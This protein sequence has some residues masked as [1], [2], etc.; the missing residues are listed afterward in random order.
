MKPSPSRPKD[1]HTVPEMHLK[2]FIDEKGMVW[3]YDKR[4]DRIWSAAPRETAVQ[5]NFY[6]VQKADDTYFDEIEHWLSGVESKASPIYDHLLHGQIPNGQERADFATFIASMY[7]CTPGMVRMYAEVVGAGYNAMTSVITA[8][9]ERFDQTMDR[10]EREVGP[11]PSS[12]R[13][14]VFEFARDPKN[15]T[16]AVA[17]AAGLPALEASDRLQRIFFDMGWEVVEPSRDTEFFITGDHPVTRIIPTLTHS[18]LRGDGGFLNKEVLVSMPL[19]PSRML[20]LRWG[21]DRPGRPR[22]VAR[23]A[24]R[25]LNHYRAFFAEA[26]LYADRRSEGI[27]SLARKHKDNRASMRVSGLGAR[28]K[29]EVRR[30]L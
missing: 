7:A 13:D 29:I 16:L 8:S 11:L 20:V 6:S 19:S 26:C 10:Y 25:D 18:P 17:R 1:H 30:K 22:P 21:K 14:K 9:R 3:S 23:E 27:G 15:Y 5:R 12:M 4:Q 28:A 24:V 2:H